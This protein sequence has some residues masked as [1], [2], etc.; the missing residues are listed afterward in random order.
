MSYNPAAVHSH[1]AEMYVNA[2][3]AAHVINTVSNW[4]G[5]IGFTQGIID[6]DH[7]S[8]DAGETQLIT[9]FAD[10]SGGQVTVTSN[11]HG[12]GLGDI[13]TISGTTS[14]NGI[15]T[16]ANPQT[17]TFE[18]TD[19]WVANDGQGAYELPSR[20]IA[21]AT[22]TFR[23]CAKGSLAPSNNNDIFDFALIKNAT[24]LVNT[25][26]RHTSGGA[27]DYNDI[28]IMGLSEVVSGD[29]IY[30][31][32]QNTTGTNNITIRHANLNMSSIAK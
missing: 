2:N 20:F 10:A 1:Y 11:G 7:L 14:Y 29:V 9:A 26:A 19:T 13:V 31:A 12:L 21:K 8:F 15:F 22:G 23:L 27:G 32:L 6:T 18:I 24:P 25:W 4:Q 5:A 16:V 17:N 28:T 3:A 30:L